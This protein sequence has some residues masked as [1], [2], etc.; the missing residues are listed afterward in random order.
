MKHAAR[1]AKRMITDIVG[2]YVELA[3]SA[4]RLVPGRS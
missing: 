2:L 4:F 1:H 3:Q